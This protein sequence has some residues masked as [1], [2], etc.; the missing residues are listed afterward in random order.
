MLNTWR[1]VGFGSAQPARI[2]ESIASSEQALASGCAQLAAAH[3]A[4]VEDEVT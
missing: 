2:A 4:A 1:K 3:E